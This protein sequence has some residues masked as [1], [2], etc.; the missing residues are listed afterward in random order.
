MTDAVRRLES[1]HLLTLYEALHPFVERLT[2]GKLDSMQDKAAKAFEKGA[3]EGLLAIADNGE[4]LLRD[5][6]QTVRAA[7]GD[8]AKLRA[9]LTE[10]IATFQVALASLVAA[11]LTQP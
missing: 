11:N 1:L 3:T 10:G 2:M 7:K 5:F 9:A 6:K 8:D 4:E